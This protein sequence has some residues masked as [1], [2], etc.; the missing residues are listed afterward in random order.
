[1]KLAIRK[2][3]ARDIMQIATPAIAGLSSQ[4]VVSIVNTAMVGRLEHTQIQLAAMGL[5]FLGNMAITSLFSSIANF[6]SS[7]FRSS[8]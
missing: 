6:F 8:S 7:M 3:L 1:M 5:G 4:M 2:T